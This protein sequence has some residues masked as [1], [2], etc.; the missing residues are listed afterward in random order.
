MVCGALL[1]NLK[2]NGRLRENWSFSQ[3][4]MTQTLKKGVNV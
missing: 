3:A 1:S 4:F 2:D